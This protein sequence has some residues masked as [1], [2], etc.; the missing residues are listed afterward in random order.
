MTI[1]FNLEELSK[2]ESSAGLPRRFN[3]GHIEFLPASV[4]VQ[5][6][7]RRLEDVQLPPHRVVIAVE[8]IGVC[9]A[10]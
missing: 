6:C 4:E 8:E 9:S 10:R 3:V 1:V 7:G 2:R 5:G